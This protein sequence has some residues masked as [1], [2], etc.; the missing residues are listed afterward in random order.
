[1]APHSRRG[2][3]LRRGALDTLRPFVWLEDDQRP[4]DWNGPADR[5]FT[6][7]RD[8][9]LER[10]I[11]EHFERVARRQPGRIAIRD[12]DTALTFGELW[13]GVSGLAETLEAETEPGDLVGILLPPERRE[14]QCRGLE[15]RP[16]FPAEQAPGHGFDLIEEQGDIL[17][18]EALVHRTLPLAM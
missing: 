3:T 18:P 12:A 2:G 13:D 17:P 15:G 14:H 4:L 1:M 11:I 8:Q 7:L 9:D 6:R 16:V 10:P 5:L